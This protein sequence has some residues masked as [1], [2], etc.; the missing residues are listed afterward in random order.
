MTAVTAKDRSKTKPRKAL[1]PQEQAERYQKLA[2]PG[3]PHRQL[4]RL[5]GTWTTVTKEWTAP[6]KPSSESTGTAE[7]KMLLGDRFLQQ[8]YSGQ[9]MGQPFSG[10]SID[11]YDNLRKKYVTT[12]M[13]T[14]GT[15]I[16]LME[17]TGSDDGKTITLKGEHEDP[18][19]G[20]MQHRAVWKILDDDHQTFEMYAPHQGTK[21]MKILEIT[22]ERKK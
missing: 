9:M 18:E 3:E 13:S 15:G 17:G 2:T 5:A 16:M 20:K 21:D 22:Y 12:W 4:A 8:E 11:G 14:S 10:M 7:M 19:G 6:G 1:D